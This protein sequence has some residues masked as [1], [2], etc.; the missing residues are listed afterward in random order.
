MNVFKGGKRTFAPSFTRSFI[1]TPLPEP[2]RAAI[3]LRYYPSSGGPFK[4]SP[5][6]TSYGTEPLLAR[7]AS[8]SLDCK[9]ERDF[10]SARTRLWI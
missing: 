3:S 4:S 1:H 6:A 5:V 7:A 2:L 8:F 9:A 10:G